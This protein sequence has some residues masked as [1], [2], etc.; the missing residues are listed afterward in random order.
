MREEFARHEMKDRECRQRLRREQAPVD[1]RV[2][3]AQSQLE[4]LV[5][6]RS[7]EYPS[8]GPRSFMAKADEAWV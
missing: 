5:R 2:L 7:S 3:L 1:G 8:V 6:L 4:L